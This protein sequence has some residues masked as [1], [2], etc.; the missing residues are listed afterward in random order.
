MQQERQQN[1]PD[2]VPPQDIK[3]EQSV[4]GAM[5]INKEAVS[6]VAEMLNPEDFYRQTHRLIFAAMLALY[7]RNEAIDLVT[8]TN[9]LQKEGKLEDAGG[10]SYLTLLA[11][12]VPTAAN[13]KYHAQIVEE[14]S[15]LR[16]L[17]EGGTRIATLG[18]EGAEEV[19]DIMD[20]AEKTILRISHRK[21]GKDFTPIGEVVGTTLDEISNLIETKGGITGLRTG[22]I[23]FD[24]MTAGLHPSDFIILA[25][26]PSMGKT[27]LALNIAQNIA[28]RGAGQGEDPKKIAFFSLEMSREQLS[29]ACSAPRQTSTPS[30]SARDRCPR[31]NGPACGKRRTNW[32][33]PKSSSMTRR[34]CASWKCAARRGACRPRKGWT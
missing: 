18:Y 16:Q 5:L 33:R 9:E 2:R 11:N 31:R 17:V 4:L 15:I 32:R 24:R 23:D 10:V 29:S 12:V 26:R 14:K 22:F 27:A 21:G 28:I 6:E 34:A 25:A 19:K 13:V 8:M 7:G 30:S 20:E 1:N 3:A